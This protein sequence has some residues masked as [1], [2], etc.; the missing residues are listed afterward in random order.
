MV[1][2]HLSDEEAETLKIVLESHLS[3]LRME[4]ADTDSMDYRVELKNRKAL[5][6][7]IA[8]LLVQAQAPA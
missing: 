6:E 4:I 7:R 5:L 3:E 1:H 2:L 8:G